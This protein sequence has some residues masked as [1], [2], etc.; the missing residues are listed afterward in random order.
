[1]SRLTSSAAV[2][3]RCHTITPV[4]VAAIPSTGFPLCLL[5]AGA[6]N[7]SLLTAEERPRG[8]LVIPLALWRATHLPNSEERRDAPYRSVRDVAEGLVSP[9]ARKTTRDLRRRD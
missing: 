6:V 4:R 9:R 1:M 2:V 5:S 3:R 7:F 8:P